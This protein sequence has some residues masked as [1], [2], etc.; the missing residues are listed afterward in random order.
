MTCWS[1]YHYR[2]DGCE[3]N[4]DG[5]PEI[6]LQCRAFEYEPGSDE[7]ERETDVKDDAAPDR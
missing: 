2:H 7:A 1:C 5:W 6:G 3:I 4:R